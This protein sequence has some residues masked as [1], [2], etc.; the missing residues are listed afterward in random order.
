MASRGSSCLLRKRVAAFAVTSIVASVLTLAAGT[1]A[2]AAGPGLVTL[3]LKAS[4]GLVQWNQRAKV[5]GKLSFQDTNTTDGESVTLSVTPPGGVKTQISVIALTASGTFSINS[6]RLRT[7]GTYT[8]TA[9]YGGNTLE[10][11]ATTDATT[12][13]TVVKLSKSA[14]TVGFKKRVTLTV[15]LDNYKQTAK[16]RVALWDAPYPKA[17]FSQVATAKVKT[18]GKGKGDATFVMRPG[19]LTAFIASWSVVTPEAVASNVVWVRVRAKVVPNTGQFGRQR[20]AHGRSGKFYLFYLP[21]CTFTGFAWIGCISMRA[22]VSPNRHG[23]AVCF[24]EQVLSG[25]TWKTDMDACGT[26]GNGSGANAQLV[27]KEKVGVPYRVMA[28]FP[29]DGVMARGDST[30]V[31]FEFILFSLSGRGAVHVRTG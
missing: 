21:I 15:H 10:E 14:R 3:T 5:S 11:A 31:Y 16:H 20:A 19:K 25:T 26:L 13:L 12:V 24:K 29:A 18:K 30:W 1:P 27:G 28:Y 22:K 4:P 17:T 23:S 8:F 9:D 7:P 6:S 2:F